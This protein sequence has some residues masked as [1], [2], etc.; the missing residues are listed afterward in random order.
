MFLPILLLPSLATADTIGRSAQG[1][2]PILPNTADYIWWYGCTPTSAG[3]MM[4]Y[5]DRNGYAGLSYTNLVPGGTA[6]ASSYTGP[7]PLAK[8]AIAS[9]GHIAD[10]YNYYGATGDPMAAHHSFDSLADFMGTSQWSLG[11]KDGSTWIYSWMDGSKFT[12]QDAF[13][14]GVWN[15]DGMYGMWEYFEYAGYNAAKT[16]FYTQ[17]TDNRSSNGFSFA[18]FKTEINSGR[19][20]M[21]QV[22]GHSMFGY[23]YSD[24]GGTDLVYLYDT[25]SP[26]P[27]SMLWDGSYDGLDMW[28]VTCFTPEGGT[29]SVP[30]P[31]SLLLLGLGLIAL[32]CFK[33]KEN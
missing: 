7:A 18:D 27:H 26:G 24:T 14:Y 2:D 15:A 6:E 32:I 30:E 4:A 25:W 16:D 33:K 3:M 11:N 31:S 5:Y 29:S 12:A 22:S 28:G 1:D 19:V 9:P 17:L 20:V 10:F 23:G 13:N 8:N 21:I